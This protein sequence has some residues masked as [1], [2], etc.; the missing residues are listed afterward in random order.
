MPTFRSLHESI[1]ESASTPVR[2]TVFGDPE[3]W[4][5]RDGDGAGVRDE[6]GDAA[7]TERDAKR[8]R[9]SDGGRR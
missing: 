8:K 2:G 5:V 4:G 1:V 6:K 9:Q 3:G 7:K